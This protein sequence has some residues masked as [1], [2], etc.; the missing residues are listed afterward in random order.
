MLRVIGRHSCLSF[1]ILN[2]KIKKY[3]NERDL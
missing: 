1:G 2:V 3:Y